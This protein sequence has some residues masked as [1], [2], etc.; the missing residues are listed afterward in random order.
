MD[1]QFFRGQASFAAA[2]SGLIATFFG[3]FLGKKLV[4]SDQELMFGV[5]GAGLLVFLCFG[6]SIGYTVRAFTGWK[7]VTFELNPKTA[8]HYAT[9]EMPLEELLRKLALDADQ[10]FDQNEKVISDVRH[11]LS[12]AL[13][14]G[15][16]QIPAWL[17][18]FIE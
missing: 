15:W 8:V 5:S 3:S 1:L 14:F 12:M 10:Y 18:L 2:V 11:F 7:P 6:L 17:L 13:L 9:Y 16:C 4:N